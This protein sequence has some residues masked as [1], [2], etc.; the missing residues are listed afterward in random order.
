MVVEGGGEEGGGGGGGRRCLE[1]MGST[2]RP[3]GLSTLACGVGVGEVEEVEVEVGG[4]G[5]AVY[6]GMPGD[7]RRRGPVW[8]TVV[9][10][11][12]VGWVA[13]WGA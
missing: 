8:Q 3:L 5:G 4:E 10:L 2:Y 12:A 7:P 1:G 9:G 13:V 11:I 6:P